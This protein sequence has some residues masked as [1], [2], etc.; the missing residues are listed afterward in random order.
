MPQAVR[1]LLGLSAVLFLT[2]LALPALG[3]HTG[4]ALLTRGWEGPAHLGAAGARLAFAW[5]ANPLVVLCWVLTLRAAPRRALCCAAAACALG[6]AVATVP[7]G[8]G[9]L[10]AGYFLWLASL[11]VALAAALAQGFAGGPSPERG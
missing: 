10:G 3:A 11:G 9:W 7:G 6:A 1:A 5:Y 8:A 4:L 2:A